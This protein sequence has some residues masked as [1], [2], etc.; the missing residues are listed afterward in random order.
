MRKRT[1]P[2]LADHPAGAAGGE[3]RGPRRG[4]NEAPPTPDRS[5]S[6]WWRASGRLRRIARSA[7]GHY[8]A[9]ISS[10][11]ANAQRR[12]FSTVYGTIGSAG[13]YDLVYARRRD[14]RSTPRDDLTAAGGGGKYES[15]QSPMTEA[16]SVPAARLPLPTSL[17]GR[18]ERTRPRLF[19][20]SACRW[21]SAALRDVCPGSSYHKLR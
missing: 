9:P 16:V 18:P 2:R 20:C 15:T 14:R 19:I 10:G 3:R 6:S 21:P 4:G 5:M 13:R 8:G 12:A 1:P 17:R 7:G 11:R